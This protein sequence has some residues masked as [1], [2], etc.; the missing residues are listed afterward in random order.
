[1][2]IKVDKDKPEKIIIQGKSGN[3]KF[4]VIR[5]LQGT[6][7]LPEV[8]LGVFITLKSP[9]KNM[10]KTAKEARIYKSY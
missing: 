7:T 5:D 1:M 9:T 8:G 2:L 4:G 3:V 10:I 6:I